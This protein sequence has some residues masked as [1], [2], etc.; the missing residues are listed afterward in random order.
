LAAAP[1]PIF[2]AA[3]TVAEILKGAH[4]SHNPSLFIQKFQDALQQMSGGLPFDRQ[5]AEVYGKIAQLRLRPSR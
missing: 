2:T 3:I 5:A 4:K 1:G